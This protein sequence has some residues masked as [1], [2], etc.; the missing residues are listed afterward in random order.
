MDKIKEIIEDLSVAALE[1]NTKIAGASVISDSGEVIYQ[2]ENFDLR[3]QG[4]ILVNVMNG[5]SS[6]SLNNYRYTVIESSSD[7]II[8]ENDGGGGFIIIVPFQGRFLVAYSL[9]GSNARENL[10]FLKSFGNKIENK[11]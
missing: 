5:E 8:A 3:N 9:P 4:N 11:L 6:F 1:E 2:T 10:S 7:G